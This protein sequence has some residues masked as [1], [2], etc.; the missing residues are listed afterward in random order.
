MDTL[1]TLIPAALVLPV[2]A[3]LVLQLREA[4]KESR[5]WQ[6]RWAREISRSVELYARPSDGRPTRPPPP[7]WDEPSK[8]RHM[9]ELETDK[10]VD[11]QLER[12]LDS[13]PPRV[14]HPK[15]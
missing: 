8:V 1:P 15:R 10:A 12:Y 7:D 13:T 4:R 3:W 6:E 2:V 14:P 9:R 5:G 11:A